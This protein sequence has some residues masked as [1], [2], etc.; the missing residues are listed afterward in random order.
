MN[1]APSVE[2]AC[3][4]TELPP[5]IAAIDAARAALAPHVLIDSTLSVARLARVFDELR[6]LLRREHGYPPLVRTTRGGAL[7]RAREALAL[8]EAE[9]LS[10]ECRAIV[11]PLVA[12]A[13]VEIESLAAAH[14][15]VVRPA[16]RAEQC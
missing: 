12:R 4:R 15:P 1:G 9:P 7:Q 13:W 8:V 14:A 2:R 16:E 10:A 6:S 11:G 5:S 3:A